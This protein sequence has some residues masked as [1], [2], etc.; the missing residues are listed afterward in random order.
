MRQQWCKGFVAGVLFV[1]LVSAF[2]FSTITAAQEFGGLNLAGGSLDF[3]P[4]FHH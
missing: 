4:D 3:E 2:P 1:V